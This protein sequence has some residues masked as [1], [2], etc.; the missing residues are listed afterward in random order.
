[1]ATVILDSMCNVKE[2]REMI[3]EAGYISCKV[4]E[5]G[6]ACNGWYEVKLI[7][8]PYVLEQIIIELWDDAD[9][10]EYIVD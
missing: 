4:E 1:M 9:L 8:D 5:C 7:D 2:T 6:V 3:E 10:T